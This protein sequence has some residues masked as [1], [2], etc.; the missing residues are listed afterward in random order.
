MERDSFEAIQQLEAVV[1]YLQQFSDDPVLGPGVMFAI[2]A[3]AE[4]MRASL[5]CIK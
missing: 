1:S 4:K 5:V 3:I 2:D